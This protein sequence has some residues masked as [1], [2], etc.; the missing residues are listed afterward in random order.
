MAIFTNTPTYVQ[1]QTNLPC[2]VRTT[3]DPSEVWLSRGP[4]AA[5]GDLGVSISLIDG[6]AL[7][8]RNLSPGGTRQQTI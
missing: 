7:G 3:S 4:V 5:V 1:A 2:A 8:G 6:G